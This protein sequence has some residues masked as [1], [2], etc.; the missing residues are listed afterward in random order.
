VV[1]QL[2]GFTLATK[3]PAT[4]A[5]ALAAR[6]HNV[7]DP[8]V[9]QK[10]IDEI[11]CLV[12]SQM[13]AIIG[14][15]ALTF[16]LALFIAWAG[17]R[18]MDEPMLGF[19]KAE[20]TL[21]AISFFGMTPFFAAFT[22]VLLWLSS[23]AAGYADNWF[24]YHRLR[25]GISNS[26]RLRFIL[27]DRGAARAAHFLDD[28]IAGLTG[29]ILLGLLL[30][31]VPAF[32]LMT[33]L[34]IDVRH[35]TLSTGQFAASIF[36]LGSEVVYTPDFWLALAG[37]MAVG[38][39]N[40]SVSFGLAMWVAIRARQV[41]ASERRAIYSALWRRFNSRPFSFLWPRKDEVVPAPP[42]PQAS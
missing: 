5:P 38:V 40:V 17:A 10:L 9:L 26:P 30:G 37:I 35:V 19:E 4:T 16:P 24:A 3:Q 18:L 32:G 7:R 25:S 41:S 20:K 33:G 39:I 12:R 42:T 23:M 36:T 29:N 14:N 1:I 11:V 22:G 28:H 27:G 6:M 34:P 13:G 31:V 8:A 15:L 21:H 2:C